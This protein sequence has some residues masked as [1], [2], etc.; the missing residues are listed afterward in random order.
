MVINNPLEAIIELHTRG[1]S[2]KDIL[3]SEDF[4]NVSISMVFLYEQREE[5]PPIHISL[6][7]AS[8]D[9]EKADRRIEYLKS[10]NPGMSIAKI[11]CP[12][13]MVAESGLMSYYGSRVYDAL[14]RHLSRELTPEEI[15]A[16][17]GELAAGTGIREALANYPFAEVYAVYESGS[18]LCIIEGGQ[19]AA[20]LGH[21]TFSRERATDIAFERLPTDA[22]FRLV[23]ET[24]AR[25]LGIEGMPR[26]NNDGY[27]SAGSAYEFLRE[28]LLKSQ[29]DL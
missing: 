18:G 20:I 26:P 29:S 28:E 10:Q 25:R 13:H 3:E 7:Y 2:I 12:A 19:P 17:Q 5:K 14:E 21:V 1:D 15:T 8:V 11:V 27:A 4:R 23:T 6:A 24:N 16:V 9:E 22:S